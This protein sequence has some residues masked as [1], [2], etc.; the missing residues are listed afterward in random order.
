[1]AFAT[2]LLTAVVFPLNVRA[3]P[4]LSA[5][6]SGP[7]RWPRVSIVVP[8]RN[9]ERGIG[10]AVDSQLRQ[11]YPDFEV[12]VVDDRSSDATRRILDARRDRRLRLVAGGEPPPGWLGKPYALDQGAR[13]A[14]GEVLLF[15][16][17]DVRYEP[18]TLRDA[19]RLLERERL[20]LLALFPRFE[21]VGFWESVLMPY[22]PIS[23]YFGLG[24]LA[25][26]DAFRW[27][28]AGGGAGNL[29]RRSAYEAVGGHA[30]IRESVIDDVRLAMRIKRAGFRC[31]MADAGDRVRVRMYRGL[32][33]IVDG[34]S[35]N[36]SYAFEGWFGL[37]FFVGTV[38]SLIA[39]WAPS[40]AFA[41]VAMGARLAAADVVLAALTFGLT[42]ALRAA[43]A[44]RQ[45]WPLWPAWTH[46]LMSAVWLGIIARSFYWRVVLREVRWR[47]RRYDSAGARF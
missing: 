25:N 46:P 19:I 15:V 44:R 34:F 35:K 36:A 21:L 28:A 42:V 12:V 20:D 30:E 29:V 1:V 32:R 7:D 26:S 41:F 17:A 31:R 22:I 23:Y 39:S 43:L 47:G 38:L 6:R 9:E 3:T 4:R 40:A 8:A 45:G 13:T 5:S 11:D 16:D 18:A 24:F 37:V 27:L 33:E 14:D 10:D 2:A